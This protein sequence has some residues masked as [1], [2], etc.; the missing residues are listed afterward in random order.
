ME[1][2]RV[3]PLHRPEKARRKARH[4]LEPRGRLPGCAHF[5]PRTWTDCDG[6]KRQANDMDRFIDY[7]EKF[8]PEED[9]WTTVSGD[10]AELPF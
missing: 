3:L 5:K 9:E 7:D 1:D 10:D 8:F 6:N 4:G 2:Q